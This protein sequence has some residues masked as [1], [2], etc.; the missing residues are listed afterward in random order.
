VRGDRGEKEGMGV[1]GEMAQTIYAHMNKW[2]IKKG[3]ETFSSKAVQR[4]SEWQSLS[5]GIY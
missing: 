2:I 4:K 5:H 3:D 1:G